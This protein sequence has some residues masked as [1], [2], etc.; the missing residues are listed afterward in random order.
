MVD[1]ID[2]LLKQILELYKI[3]YYGSVTVNCEVLLNKELTKKQRVKALLLGGLAYQKRRL[4]YRALD[5]LQEAFELLSNKELE[6]II[7]NMSFQN[8]SFKKEFLEISAHL[9]SNLLKE[10]KFFQYC[11]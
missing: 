4:H 3:G 5:L 9:E 10:D 11:C 1:R 7:D 8:N 6:K 2:Y